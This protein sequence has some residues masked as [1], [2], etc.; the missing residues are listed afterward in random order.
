MIHRHVDRYVQLHR[1]LGK[2]FDAQEKA[3]RQFATFLAGRAAA[4][5]T[6]ELMLEWVGEAS[7]SNAA[8]IRFDL[9]RAFAEFLRG[10]DPRHEAPTAGL[11][12]RGRQRRPAPHILMP[13]QI[14]RIVAEAQNVPG[15]APISP[16]TYHHLFGL[17]ASTGLRISEAL[18]LRL[19]DLADNGLMV[20]C[21]KFGKSRLVPLHASTR[22]ALERYLEVRR[23]LHDASDDFFV[24]GHGRAP[25][26]TRAHVIFVRI[27]RRL[28]YRNPTGPGPR[29]HDLR[30]TFA[31]RSLEACGNDQQAVLR[32][33]RTLSTYLGH[34]DVANT[35]W[36][37][38]AT[39]V[40]LRTI[41]SAAE[42]AFV[43]GAA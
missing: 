17:L 24:L 16:L 28:G 25:T 22:A 5:I 33:M 3:L 15:Q 23:K 41:A 20:R 37:L 18:S 8:R 12:G 4:F 30:H 42:S 2:K 14:A 11:L 7:T 34:V 9:A 39:P 27:V 13:D 1:A 29:L 32:H 10:E 36:Y 38:E 19:D 6:A 43:G 31:V 40:L 35:Y 26:A 21:G